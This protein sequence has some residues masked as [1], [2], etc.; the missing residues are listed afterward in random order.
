MYSEIMEARRLRTLDEIDVAGK[1]VIVR[2]DYNVVTNEKG[3]VSEAEDYRIR[4]SVP[5]LTELIKKG[6]K[7]V[8]LPRRGRDGDPP[9]QLDLTPVHARLEQLLGK[10]VE[11]IA[12]LTGPDAQTRVQVMASGEITMLPNV[13]SDPREAE[14]SEQFAQELAALGDVYVNEAFGEAHRAHTSLTLLAEKLPSAAGRRVQLEVESLSKVANNVARPYIVLAS[15]A[16]L[17]DKIGMLRSLTE[18]AD[19]VCI[20]GKI[21]NVFLAAAGKLAPA[22]FHGEEV[23][24][25]QSLLAAAKGKLKL[26]L[27]IVTGSEDGQHYVKT[28]PVEALTAEMPAWDIGSATVQNFLKVCASA[29]TIVWNGPM[30]RLEVAMYAEGTRQLAQGL[31]GL[32]AYRVVGGGDTVTALHQFKLAE[33]FNHISVGGGAMISFLEG[34]RM[35]ALEPLYTT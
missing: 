32:L 9:A 30:G 26:P 15:G 33:K 18:K 28:V 4:T 12:E 19:V 21:A 2:A 35:P 11:R 31:A 25:A 5:T 14:V 34:K 22:Q 16:K 27:D 23:A 10:R 17:E 29:K 13:R 8:V 20:G 7:V 1:R 24:A 3:E 6:A